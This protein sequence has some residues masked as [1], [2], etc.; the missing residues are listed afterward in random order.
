MLRWDEDKWVLQQ[1]RLQRD[2]GGGGEGG[3]GGGNGGEVWVPWTSVRDGVSEEGSGDSSAVMKRIVDLCLRP[4]ASASD[5]VLEHFH[6]DDTLNS[7]RQAA[8]AQAGIPEAGEGAPPETPSS[9]CKPS[10]RIAAF[11]SNVTALHTWLSGTFSQ[12]L[13]AQQ[14]ANLT[15][16]SNNMQLLPSILAAQ[17]AFEH[18]LWFRGKKAASFPWDK[19][20]THLYPDA[21]RGVLSPK[22]YVVSQHMQGVLTLLDYQHILQRRYCLPAALAAIT[23][24]RFPFMGQY[25]SFVVPLLL[26]I[27]NNEEALKAD[28]VRALHHFLREVNPADIQWNGLHQAIF[29]EVSTLLYRTEPAVVATAWPCVATLLPILQRPP[30][31]MQDS[32]YDEVWMRV[33]SF[34]TFEA[35]PRK[36]LVIARAITPLIKVSGVYCVLH[37]RAILQ[38]LS[39]MVAPKRSPA[40][41][42]TSTAIGNN[43]VDAVAG[44]DDEDDEDGMHAGVL[45]AAVHALLAFCDQ[46]HA[47]PSRQKA[48]AIQTAYDVVCARLSSSPASAA[49]HDLHTL[50]TALASH[51]SSSS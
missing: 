51:L 11:V 37:T 48:Q 8:Q 40:P 12:W 27:I 3:E 20:C 36:Q 21:K 41:T 26:N 10:K 33:L 28:A 17:L 7:L 44:G 6:Q 18:S 32:V 13:D 34:S 5:A 50:K 25:I 1:Q 30:S 42:T 43:G 38:L 31:S 14:P 29:K 47:R 16:A 4:P 24:T 19:L 22:E 39:G 46:T 2:G 15:A 45:E 49:H 23:T 35:A 9:T